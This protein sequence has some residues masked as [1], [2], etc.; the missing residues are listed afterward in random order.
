MNIFGK[1]CDICFYQADICVY[2]HTHT[3][4]HIYIYV[5]VYIYIYIYMILYIYITYIAQIASPSSTRA[6]ASCFC[7]VTYGGEV[8]IFVF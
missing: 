3:H 4:T 7:N 2:I 1:R 5:Y 6:K 8:V